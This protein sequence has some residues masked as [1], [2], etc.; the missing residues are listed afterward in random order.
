M[1]SEDEDQKSLASS[2]SYSDSKSRVQLNDDSIEDSAPEENDENEKRRESNDNIK[3]IVKDGPTSKNADLF[4]DI[5]FEFVANPSTQNPVI[6]LLH[7]VPRHERPLIERL[8]RGQ[9]F[10]DLREGF[11]GWNKK[12]VHMYL[13]QDLRHLFINKVRGDEIGEVV[14]IE[15]VRIANVACMEL[16]DISKALPEFKNLKVLTLVI[17]HENQPQNLK[18]LP[19]STIYNLVPDKSCVRV[20]EKV[21]LYRR[22]NRQIVEGTVVRCDFQ[23]PSNVIVHVK[24]TGEEIKVVAESLTREAT[25]QGQ[26]IA[27]EIVWDWY[28]GISRLKKIIQSCRRASI[29]LDKKYQDLCEEEMRVSSCDKKVAEKWH[30]SILTSGG[31]FPRVFIGSRWKDCRVIPSCY[32]RCSSNLDAILIAPKQSLEG[33]GKPS[34]LYKTHSPWKFETLLSR[35]ERQSSLSE[36]ANERKS[37][38]SADSKYRSGLEASFPSPCDTL[39]YRII[40]PVRM[41]EIGTFASRSSTMGTDDINSSSLSRS[42]I[43]TSS[44]K[45]TKLISR[46]P[47]EHSPPLMRKSTTRERKYQNLETWKLLSIA[48][49][50]RHEGKI[51]AK[52]DTFE[53]GVGN[54]LQKGQK[55]EKDMVKRMESQ[56]VDHSEKIKRRR[57]SQNHSM[58]E[59]DFFLNG[60]PPRSITIFKLKNMQLLEDQKCPAFQG[61]YYSIGLRVK[62]GNKETVVSLECHTEKELEYWRRQF[63][64]LREVNSEISIPVRTRAAF[65]VHNDLKWQGSFEEH[66]EFYCKRRHVME[67][68]DITLKPDVVERFRCSV[69]KNKSS[70]S[71]KIIHVCPVKGCGFQMCTACA[72]ENSVIGEGGF[73]EVHLAINKNLANKTPCVIKIFK[74]R[75]GHSALKKRM[76]ETDVLFRLQAHPNIVKYQGYGGPNARGQLW[77]VMECCEGG[78]VL[79]LI[80]GMRTLMTEL[81]IAYILHCVLRALAFL[82]EKKIAHK[83]IKAANILLTIEG[84]VKLSDFGIS[85]EVEIE[86]LPHEDADK[87]RLQAGSPPWMPPEV[88]EGKNV[89]VKG[90]IWSLGITAIEMAE[91]R[92]PNS[93]LNDLKKLRNK[94]LHGS[95][96]RLGNKMKLEKAPKEGDAKEWSHNFR[97]FVSSCFIKNA[98]ERPTAVDLLEQFPFMDQEQFKVTAFCQNMLE[99]MDEAGIFEIDMRERRKKITT[100]SDPPALICRKSL[101]HLI[102]YSDYEG[103]SND[104]KEDNDREETIG[105]QKSTIS[106]RYI[107]AKP[108]KIIHIKDRL[109]GGEEERQKKIARIKKKYP[110]K[111]KRTVDITQ[112]GFFKLAANS[113]KENGKGL[114][115]FQLT[116]DNYESPHIKMEKNN[117]P[118]AAALPMFQL[119]RDN[120]RVPNSKE[121]TKYDAKGTESS[122]GQANAVHTPGIS[123]PGV[124]EKKEDIDS[125]SGSG[126]RTAGAVIPGGPPLNVGSDLVA[127]SATRPTS[128]TS[129]GLPLANDRK[130]R[131]KVAR[132]TMSR[133]LFKDPEQTH[134]FYTEGKKRTLMTERCIVDSEGNVSTVTGKVAEKQLRHY[135]KNDLVNVSKLGSGASGEQPHRQIKSFGSFFIFVPFRA[136]AQGISHTDGAICGT[137]GD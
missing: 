61:T 133:R 42:S 49:T 110:N 92:A 122:G 57:S 102:R 99:V 63:R 17:L 59:P 2:R 83:D 119:T 97:G 115:M 55:H 27:K 48:D 81:H 1:T 85:D 117:K 125:C 137:K 32:V 111:D 71:S 6:R 33:K 24:N 38:L 132:R 39:P 127:A 12:K 90:D 123:I 82:H 3:L 73:S 60:R 31:L 34:H 107:R 135:R 106:P 114:P 105:T 88:W 28:C 47:S 80:Q 29:D 18:T 104:E 5:T 8:L 86:D 20:G 45:G 36:I 41:K 10:V 58:S 87:P 54:F 68:I 22:K 16:E 95:A 78:S 52:L 128:G 96:P 15:S 118:A 89:T 69:C 7:T 53:K 98:K 101:L 72:K 13:S 124:T 14:K 74:K 84:F 103:Y 37:K 94:I 116:Q 91:G 23:N 9:R 126:K 19:R 30:K 77:I 131:P 43:I 66:F 93:H 79:D 62:C 40:N 51:S 67:C 25:L 44:F 21:N 46:A 11:F 100:N 129:E 108:K 75:I 121:D 120:F 35:R 76:A 56:I 134:Q 64:Y 50:L 4:T 70:G 26:D 113:A 112:W 109:F 130:R 136:C 65:R